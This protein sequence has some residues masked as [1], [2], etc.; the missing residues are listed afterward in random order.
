[1]ADVYRRIESCDWPYLLAHDQLLA[2][3]AKG[4][5]FKQFKEG[6]I[7]W[8]PTYKYQ[9]GTSLYERR[10]DKKKRMPAWCDR[11]QFIGDEIVQLCYARCDSL[12]ISDHKPV[13]ALFEVVAREVISD[14]KRLVYD[15]LIR[16][17]D[18][19]ENQAIPKVA[20]SPE[21][22]ELGEVRF[23]DLRHTKLVIE[24]TGSVTVVEF[25]F[26]PKTNNGLLASKQR[27]AASLTSINTC[28]SKWLR[29]TP[30]FGIIPPHE[31]VE[32]TLSVHVTPQ[33]SHA[34]QTG[35]EALDDILILSLEN[36]RDY[37]IPVSGVYQ[38]S[39][40]GATIEYLVN[41]RNK[42]R[43]NTQ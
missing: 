29:V 38:K 28:G 32:I 37:F 21:S 40:M 20:I 33:S 39:C 31:S 11:I 10:E 16:Q 19:W 27:D 2:E 24:N 26:V 1:M 4:N 42:R 35:A 22:I 41:V 14:R 13:Y 15:S 34:L 18:S 3:K 43:R 30:E 5:A 23:D 17:L 8:A 36:G 7:N 12:K 25:R 9:P 6:P